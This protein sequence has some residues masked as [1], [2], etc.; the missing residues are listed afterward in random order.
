[1]ELQ[2]QAPGYAKLALN[3]HKLLPLA[4]LEKATDYLNKALNLVQRQPE[5]HRRIEYAAYGLEYA[6]IMV[7]LLPLYANL[8]AAGVNIGFPR[9]SKQPLL[10]VDQE[11]IRKW[12]AEAKG[13]GDARKKMLFSPENTNSFRLDEGLFAFAEEIRKHRPW[14]HRVSDALKRIHARRGNLQD[15]REAGFEPD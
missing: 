12:L 9:D 3:W 8:Q 2:G 15:E 14:H 11:Q 13:L 10:G 5:Y 7:Q 6:K 1:M 4:E